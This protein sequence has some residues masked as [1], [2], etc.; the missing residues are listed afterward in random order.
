MLE[1]ISHA[2]ADRRTAA[3]I[4]R[5]EKIYRIEEINQEES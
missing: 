1:G 4:S 2:K 3:N 5:D